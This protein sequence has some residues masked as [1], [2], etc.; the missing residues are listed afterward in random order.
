MYMSMCGGVGATNWL[1]LKHE[2]H[3]SL[4][5]FIGCSQILECAKSL[6]IGLGTRLLPTKEYGRNL[7]F[8][9]SFGPCPS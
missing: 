9:T 5:N 6:G 2:S 3:H 1:V 8:S 4:Y 7:A